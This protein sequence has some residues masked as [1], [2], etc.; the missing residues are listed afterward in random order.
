MWICFSEHEFNTGELAPEN[1]LD[2]Q[3]RLLLCSSWATACLELVQ[4]W[5]LA[6]KLPVLQILLGNTPGFWIF[7][8]CTVIHASCLNTRLSLCACWGR[9]KLNGST[10]PVAKMTKCWRAIAQ[11]LPWKLHLFQWWNFQLCFRISCWC[12]ETKQNGDEISTTTE[13]NTLVTLKKTLYYFYKK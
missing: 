11:K 8:T 9:K 7:G 4:F 5:E 6:E 2:W 12:P 3:L 13:S 10:S 1:F